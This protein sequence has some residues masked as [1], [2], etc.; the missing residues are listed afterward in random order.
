MDTGLEPKEAKTP[1]VASRLAVKPI[2]TTTSFRMQAY[3]SLKRAILEMDVYDHPGEI[4]LDERQL[5]RDLGVSRTPIREAMSLLEQEGF[6]K[7][8]PRRGVFVV[9]KTKREIV[10]MI[11]VW[12]ALESMA[13][14]LVSLN[15]TEQEI[16]S[17]RHLF[18]GFRNGEQTDHLEEYSEAN[19][20]FHSAI[21]R[22]S[23]CQLI[24]DLTKNLFI[25]M[26]AIRKVTISE[27]NRAQR[28]IQDHMEIVEALEARDVDRAER[29]VRQHSLDLAAHVETHCH[30]LD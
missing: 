2:D 7:T 10:E 12:A 30:H 4:R 24:A 6:V 8:L 21:I 25:H 18:D 3:N 19:I 11:L 17:L 26:R 27:D 23:K 15:A 1:S 29:L 5:S 20:A 14:R 22:L 9:R 13:A 28:S 16:A